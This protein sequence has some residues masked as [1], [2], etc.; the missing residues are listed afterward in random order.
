[1]ALAP[2]TRA[3]V[4]RAAGSP[5]APGEPADR[6]SSALFVTALL[7]GIV[8]LGLTFSGEDFGTGTDATSLEVVIVTTQRDPPLTTPD[9][10]LLAQQ[11]L[12]GSGNTREE[13][14]LQTAPGQAI[15]ADPFQAP[16][17]GAPVPQLEGVATSAT[18]EDQSLVAAAEASRR[19]RDPGERDPRTQTASSTLPRNT[20]S[21]DV[22]GRPSDQTW[23][24]GA[25][26][27][28]LLVSASTRES[29]IASYLAQWKQ[30]VE[31]VGTLNYPVQAKLRATGRFPTLEVAIAADGAL[32]D[33]RIS[34]SS[35]EK[36][37]DQAAIDI[38]RMAAPFEPFPEPLRQDYDVLRFAYEWQ[39]TRGE[40]TLSGTARGP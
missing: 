17:S 34:R 7:H 15:V 22:L 24:T 1:M 3:P 40:T 16:S 9:S 19:F 37:L 29:R 31:L 18:P 36:R 2:Q 4:S 11:N 35:G 33:V 20:T 21:V 27:R 25:G 28:E 23:V 5:A 26:P 14:M 12:R 39:F 13:L 10:Q 38:L 8:I 30:K 6:L 32:Q